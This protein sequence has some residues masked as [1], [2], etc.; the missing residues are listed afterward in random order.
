MLDLS[1][2]LALVALAL[3]AGCAAQPQAATLHP[4]RLGSIP[5]QACGG[6]TLAGQPTRADFEEARKQGFKTVVN[7]RKPGEF[8]DFDEKALVESLGMNYISLPWHGEAE[9]TDAIFTEGRKSLRDAQQPLL[10]HCATANRVGAIWLAYRVLD[11]G[12]A[13]DAALAEAK[14]IGLKTPGFETKA[15]DYITRTKG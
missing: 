9:L 3:L 1:H 12:V 10:V 15:K 7:Y 5:A 4:A 6:I 2:T 11:K 8:A 13:F 14:A